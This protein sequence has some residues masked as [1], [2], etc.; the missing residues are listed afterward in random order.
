MAR[1]CLTNRELAV[2]S[3]IKQ[4]RLTKLAGGLGLLLAWGLV[5]TAGSTWAQSSF[6]GLGHL[7][8]SSSRATAIS[9]DGA[10]VVGASDNGTQEEAFRWTA[11]TGMLGLGGLDDGPSAANAVSADGAVVVGRAQRGGE[12]EAFLWTEAGG[13][14]G[15][16]LLDEGRSEAFGVSADGSVVVGESG[17][18]AIRCGFLLGISCDPLVPGTE[19]AFRWTAAGGMVDLG[20]T[21]P[22]VDDSDLGSSAR[23]VTPDGSQAVGETFR[24]SFFC[25]GIGGGGCAPLRMPMVASRWVGSNPGQIIDP[26]LA[27]AFA[28]SS[29]GSIT[30]GGG[31]TTPNTGA[32]RPAFHSAQGGVVILGSENDFGRLARAVS[33]DGRVVVGDHGLTVDGVTVPIKTLLAQLFELDLTGWTL[34]ELSGNDIKSAYGMSAD[35]LTIVGSGRNPFNQVEAWIARLD[36]LPTTAELATLPVFLPRTTRDGN[37]LN[38][39]GLLSAT[40]PRSRS[41][42]VGTTVTIFA[43]LLNNSQVDAIGCRINLGSALPVTLDFHRSD[44]ATNETVGPQ[45]MAVDIPAGAFQTFVIGLTPT[46]AFSGSELQLNTD[47]ANATPAPYNPGINSIILSASQTPVAD[48]IAVAATASND[49]IA[50]LGFPSNQGAFAVA[51]ANLGIAARITASIDVGEVPVTA[52]ICQTDPLTGACLGPI[53]KSVSLDMAAGASPSFAVFLESEGIVSANASRSRVFV[54]FHDETDELRG[55]TSV[56]VNT[57][58]PSF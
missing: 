51:T 7:G 14:L 13:M 27:T 41:A 4:H 40:L 23:A 35:G 49:G 32:H 21:D 8:G 58:A 6:E 44:P 39:R 42:Q 36:R 15:L 56:A 10:T 50:E 25:F 46:A 24:Y 52:F 22:G 45:N 34:F 3:P 54:N 16:G 55:A 53:A 5:A 33:A 31:D 11:A 9:A 43:S 17:R 38:S 12:D 20:I 28:V 47:C 2:T 19:R 30:A 18:Q 29:D 37:L 26:N 48:I 57:E 1:S